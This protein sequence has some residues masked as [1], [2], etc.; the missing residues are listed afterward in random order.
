[1]AINRAPARRFD[2]TDEEL[3][4]IRAAHQAPL[5]RLGFL[6]MVIARPWLMV[7]TARILASGVDRFLFGN[8]E[9]RW[10]I[11]A[12]RARQAVPDAAT[13]AGWYPEEDVL[14][15]IRSLLRRDM[16]V[17]EL[18][19]GAGRISRHLAEHVR[20][21]MCTDVSR[22][23]VSE[24]RQNLA[25][26]PNVRVEVSNGF[27]LAGFADRS[28]D[29]V[30]AAGVFGYLDPAQLL[31][32][33]D[34]IHR[35]LRDDGTL[36]FSIELIDD[37]LGADAALER[38]RHGARHRRVSASVERPYCRAQLEAWLRI[39]ELVPAG[40]NHDGEAGRSNVVARR[41]ISG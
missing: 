39:A 15:S 9:L 22:R 38:A 2:L 35:V 13:G 36:M 11:S 27:S 16:D 14:G 4:R 7:E 21:L 6:R 28:F 19:C 34:E 20:T 25:A 5:G 37:P 32:L 23:M 31:G 29:L 40:V 3:R 26:H 41:P 12:E 10:L 24:A 17:L 33:F 1:M 18:G 8:S 30:L